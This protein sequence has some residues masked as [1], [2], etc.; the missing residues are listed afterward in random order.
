MAEPLHKRVLAVLSAKPETRLSLTEIANQLGMPVG[1]GHRQNVLALDAALNRLC[2]NW[3]VRF[4]L[5]HAARPEFAYWRPAR[6]IGEE[7]PNG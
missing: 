3:D 5:P 4:H 7:Q 2:Q 6:P 1:K